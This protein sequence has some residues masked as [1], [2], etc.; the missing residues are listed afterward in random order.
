MM[1]THNFAW[2][3]AHVVQGKAKSNFVHLPNKNISR[4]PTTSSTLQALA[5]LTTPPGTI[6]TENFRKVS[7]T[8][9]LSPQ[10]AGSTTMLLIWSSGYRAKT[11]RSTTHHTLL[12]N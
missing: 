1:D 8:A 6:S 11:P 10:A 3:I 12:Q 4:S 5:P 9:W 2:K 7:T